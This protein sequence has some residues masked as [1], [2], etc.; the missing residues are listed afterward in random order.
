M[1]T[2]PLPDFCWPVD[3]SL[4]AQDYDAQVGTGE[5]AVPLYSDDV[6]AYAEAMAGQTLRVLTGFR[7]GGCPITVRP[8]RA[9]CSPAT[10]RTYP[11]YGAGAST[12]WFPV[13][14]GGEW[15][16]IGCGSH[17]GACGCT[18]VH[19]IRLHTVVGA[20]TEVKVDGVELDPSAYRLDGDALVR[21]DGDSWPLCQNIEA[22]DTEPGTWSVTYTPGE[23]VDGLGAQAA[24]LLALEFAKA[25]TGNGN[26]ALP[27]GVQTVARGGVTMT[28]AAGIFPGGITGIRMVD[29]YVMRWNPNHLSGR[30]VVWSPD[31]PR[32][33]RVGP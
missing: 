11:A 27:P 30:P 14:Y 25:C 29:A 13:Q 32:P 22:A 2:P 3:T 16:N 8:C 6:K 18:R 7:V 4:C 33:R 9:G 21:V 20:V 23:A 1:T 5:N 28:I 31:V 19:E 10:Y 15:L 26:C 24:G 12:A 17:L